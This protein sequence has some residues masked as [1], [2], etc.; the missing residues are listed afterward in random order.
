MTSDDIRNNIH[1]TGSNKWNATAG[2]WPTSFT[3]PAN[4]TQIIFAVPTS[5]KNISTHKFIKM[6]NIAL[7]TYYFDNDGELRT[8]TNNLSVDGAASGTGYPYQIWTIDPEGAFDS[9]TVY[10]ISYGST[11][12]Q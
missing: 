12:Q 6:S 7:G 2:S 4:S 9:T 1:A 3:V 8:P 5:A 11:K 10:T